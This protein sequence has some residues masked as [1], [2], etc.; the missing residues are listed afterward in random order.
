MCDAR[1]RSFL[2]FPR[3]LQTPFAGIIARE[4]LIILKESN[5]G[6][7][8]EPLIGEVISSA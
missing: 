5:E 3:H 4:R 8:R 1:F 7:D 6:R 2:Y